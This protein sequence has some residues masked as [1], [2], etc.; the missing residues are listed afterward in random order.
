MARC[1]VYIEDEGLAAAVRFAFVDGFKKDSPAHQMAN[2]IRQ[3]LDD[4]A[5]GGVLTALEV[6][7]QGKLELDQV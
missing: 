4:M 6:P 1:E 2:H 5:T 3:V 7:G